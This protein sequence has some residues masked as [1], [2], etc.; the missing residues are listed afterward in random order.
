MGRADVESSGFRWDYK[1]GDPRNDDYVRG[2]GW[3]RNWGIG[4][5][6]DV[7]V[8]QV[9]EV[10]TFCKRELLRLYACAIVEADVSK[11]ELPSPPSFRS[12]LIGCIPCRV[13]T[14][15]LHFT[16]HFGIRWLSLHF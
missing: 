7:E 15:A 9:F 2:R 14:H 16:H 5:W 6:R 12:S 3:C 10:C 4:S 13:T 8:A 1:L 11:A